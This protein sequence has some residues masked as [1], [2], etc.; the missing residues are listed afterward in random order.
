MRNFLRC[1]IGAMLLCGAISAFASVASDAESLQ[2]LH[3]EFDGRGDARDVAM[4]AFYSE[5]FAGVFTPESLRALSETDLRTAFATARLLAF[6]QRES[7]YVADLR[8]AFSEIA[9]RKLAKPAEVQDMFAAY[10]GAREFDAARALARAFPKVELEPVPAVVDV[11]TLEAGKPALLRIEAA[12][13]PWIRE[14]VALVN[15]PQIIVVGHP[16]CHFSRNSTAAIEADA[17]LAKTFAR[18]AVWVAPNDLSFNEASFLEWN[19]AH[20]Q[21]A[22]FPVDLP[23]DWSMID[24][25]STPTFY[26]LTD[27]K[28][29]ESVSGWPKEGNREAV[30]AAMRKIGL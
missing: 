4:R 17:V 11:P 8:D 12:G 2:K 28:L 13:Q 15:G 10:I 9:A 29:I 5:K 21:S 1:S 27:G 16:N 6:D 19:L 20:P 14:N 24:F 3:D 23:A 22:I 7:Q 25:S 18:H 30:I 26:F